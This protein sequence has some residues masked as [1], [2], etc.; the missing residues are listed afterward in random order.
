MKCAYCGK[1][2]EILLE[3]G[4]IKEACP[5]CFVEFVLKLLKEKWD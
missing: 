3:R 5:D 4:E 2:S 1:D